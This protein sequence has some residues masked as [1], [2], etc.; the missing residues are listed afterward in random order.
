MDAIPGVGPA[1]ATA[2]VAS[3]ADAKGFGS[4][5]LRLGS[6][7]AEA[8]LKRGKDKLGS[9]SKQ[10]DRYLRSLFT[11]GAL[12]VIRYAKVH[13]TG[14]RPGLRSCCRVATKVAAIALANKIARMAGA[15]MARG[16]TTGSPPHWQHKRNC[17]AYP[18]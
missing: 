11:A 17:A 10:G 14:H 5:L 16:D 6:A 9:I 8:E 13:A 1:F 2:L 4:G 12:A 15:M 18:V 3:V 7:R